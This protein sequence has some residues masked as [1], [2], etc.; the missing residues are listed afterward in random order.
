MFNRTCTGYTTDN[1]VEGT[2]MEAYGKK[3]NS[4][5]IYLFLIDGLV[6]DIR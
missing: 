5:I 1:W 4:K 2:Q 3:A 6:Q